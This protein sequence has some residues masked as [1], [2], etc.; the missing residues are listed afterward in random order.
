MSYL[1]YIK[2]MTQEIINWNTCIGFV[3]VVDILWTTWCL[4]MFCEHISGSYYVV[5][6]WTWCF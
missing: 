6:K 3:G 2:G 4:A 5:I 1:T